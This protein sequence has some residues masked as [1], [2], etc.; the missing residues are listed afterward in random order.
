MKA[1]IYARYSSD[2][3]KG[4]S[5]GQQ[6]EICQGY[7]SRNGLEVVGIYSDA[8]QSGTS[9]N[10]AAFQQM[11]ADARAGEWQ[12]VVVYKLDRF[13]RDRYASA[14]Y[15]HQLRK[16]GVT[17][18]SATEAIPDTPEGILLEAVLEGTAEFYSRQL[19]QNVR[20]GMMDNARRCLANGNRLYGYRT[21]EDGRYV[22]DER[23]A[24]MIREGFELRASGET[25]GGVATKMHDKMGT[26][27]K[28]AYNIFSQAFKNRRYMGE[29]SWGGVT[30]PGGMPAIVSEGEWL[31]VQGIKARPRRKPHSYPLSGLIFDQDG[32]PWH[33]ESARGRS[34][35]YRY[36]SNGSVRVRCEG[37]ERA[38]F[39]AIREAMSD[40]E[41]VR[42]VA[43]GMMEILSAPDDT[44]SRL[45]AARRELQNLNDMAAKVGADDSLAR[46]IVSAR[47]EV[48]DL[49]A[50]E[51]A[52]ETASR[53]DMKSIE[54]WLSRFV[55]TQ[56]PEAI[57]AFVRRVNV[58]IADGEISGAEVVFSWQENEPPQGFVSAKDGTP[59]EINENL[60]VYPW[61]FVLQV[62]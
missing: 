23:E 9:D 12:H 58:S 55:G 48:A 54:A 2:R 39:S 60:S 56:S 7:C 10:R 51:Q 52:R 14:V 18:V 24:S 57:T 25:I 44:S 19:G 20:R 11:V 49:E 43:A 35:E 31:A 15:K 1:V 27:Y 36:Y 30:V 38:V 32:N 61:G 5:I 21:G 29:Y 6:V 3:Q 22:I 4:E 8:A 17:V 34:S 16:H 41:L 59:Y 46:R 40:A 47:A 45:S 50:A 53:A 62:A 26:S 42:S 37:L 28:R 13:A 33:G